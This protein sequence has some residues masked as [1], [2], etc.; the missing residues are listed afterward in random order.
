MVL[1]SAF[2]PGAKAEPKIRYYFFFSLSVLLRD[3]STD[4]F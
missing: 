1:S 2:D 4:M 3:I